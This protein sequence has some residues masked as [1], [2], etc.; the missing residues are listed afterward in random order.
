[1]LKQKLTQILLYKLLKETTIHFYCLLGKSRFSDVCTI[2]KL[3]E[4]N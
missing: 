1:M 4:L 3:K 2:M